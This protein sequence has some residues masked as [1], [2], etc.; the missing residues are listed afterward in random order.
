M[1]SLEQR[2][3]GL[4]VTRRELV[5]RAAGIIAAPAVLRADRALAQVGPLAGMGPLPF[6]TGAITSIIPATASS[7]YSRSLDGKN[8]SS[9]GTFATGSLL[10]HAWSPKLG[11]F[12]ALGSGANGFYGPDGITW[13][14]AANYPTPDHWNRVVWVSGKNWFCGVGGKSGG[15]DQKV[16]LSSD[17]NNFTVAASLPVAGNWRALDYSPTLGSGFG[18]VVAISSTSGGANVAIAYSDDGGQTWTAGTIAAAVTW[19]G[20]KWIPFL[21]LFLATSNGTVYATS[22]DGITFT[23]AGGALPASSSVTSQAAACSSSLICVL[24]GSITGT[25]TSPDASTWTSH[26]SVFSAALTSIIYSNALALFIA[27]G[28]GPTYWSPDGFAWTAGTTLA[29]DLWTSVAVTG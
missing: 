10:C 28:N 22:I 23:T 14:A 15:L 11:L 18:R 4:W 25:L 29:A 26:S 1:S 13:T 16:T 27:I 2:R 17:G 21:S 12:A 19:G 7:F 20:V 24:S 6:H 9:P 5:R 3:S 8:W